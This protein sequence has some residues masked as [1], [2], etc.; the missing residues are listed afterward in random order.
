LAITQ[1]FVY[2][3]PASLKETLALLAQ[4]DNFAILAGGTDLIDMIKEGAVQPDVVVD[5]KGLASLSEIRF[6]GSTLDIGAG[7]TFT[8]LIESEIIKEKFPVIAECARTVGSLGIRN[9]AT[10]AGNICSGVPCTDSGPV[11]CAYEALVLTEGPKGAR[12][13]KA[14]DWFIAPRKT[15]L[16]KGEIVVGVRIPYPKKRHSGCWVKLRRYG[17]QDLAQVN[18]LVLAF[19]DGTFRISYGAVAPVPVRAKK[20]ERMLNGQ[21]PTPDLLEKVTRLVEEEIKPI[22]DIRATGEYRMHLAKVMLAR[23]VEAA[24]GRLDGKGPEYG[25]SVI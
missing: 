20:I 6:K 12:K 10:L 8:D 14:E 7:V 21:K 22:T 5:I 4:H 17:G 23:G 24:M 19:E 1:E 16:E 15:A 9:R 25:K 2:L 3:K 11:L 13:I 18:L